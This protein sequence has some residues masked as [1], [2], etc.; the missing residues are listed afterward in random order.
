M[1]FKFAEIDE[2]AYKLGIDV[3]KEPNLLYIAKQCLLEPL[4]CNWIP[5]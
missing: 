1:S 3:V 4:P 5:W 2:Q